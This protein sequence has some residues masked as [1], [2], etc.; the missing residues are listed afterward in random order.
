MQA[1]KGDMDRDE[2]TLDS[3][4]KEENSFEYHLLLGISWLWLEGGFSGGGGMK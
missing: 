4:E 1:L 3:L 2:D